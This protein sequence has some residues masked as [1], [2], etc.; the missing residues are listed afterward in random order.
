[1]GFGMKGKIPCSVCEFHER[2][3]IIMAHRRTSTLVCCCG[4]NSRDGEVD[5]LCGAYEFY[6]SSLTN[7]LSWA[8]KKKECEDKVS[9]NLYTPLA[10]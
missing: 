4:F 1:M 6:F 8:Q 9:S 10:P 5:T 7:I 2:P 3:W